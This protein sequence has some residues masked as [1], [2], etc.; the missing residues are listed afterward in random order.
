VGLAV[1]EMPMAAMVARQVEVAV[2]RVMVQPLV[3]VEMRLWAVEVAVVL[4]Q[5]HTKLQL[6]AGTVCMAAVAGQVAQIAA[7]PCQEKVCLVAMV[8]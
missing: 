7:L 4:I 5:A 8:D 2:A 1:Q 3:Q 6:L